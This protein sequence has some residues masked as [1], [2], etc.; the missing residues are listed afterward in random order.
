MYPAYGQPGSPTGSPFSPQPAKK[1]RAGLIIGIIVLLVVL[2]G[3][4][5]AAL[6]AFSG[7]NSGGNSPTGTVGPSATATPQ[8]LFHDALTSNTNGWADAAG[9]C[10]FSA[11]GYHVTNGYICYAPAGE[12]G[13][14]SFTVQ[15]KQLSGPVSHTHGIVFRRQSR[16]NYYGFEVDAEGEWVF[17]KAV[18]DTYTTLHDFSTNPAIQSGL[19]TVNTLKVVAK[20]SHFDFYVNDTLVGSADDSTFTSTGKWG[21]SAD[22]SIDVLY[23]NLTI[24]AVS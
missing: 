15:T 17:Y 4:G 8:T 6:S 22:E 1:S 24:S 7:K 23:S 13:D 10:F 3:G 11:D 18:N 14:A 20:G 19:N 21:L 5:V 9:E 12:Y 16:G 2:I